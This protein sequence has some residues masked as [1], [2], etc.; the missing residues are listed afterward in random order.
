MGL[1]RY[2]LTNQGVD[3]EG[4]EEKHLCFTLEEVQ[5]KTRGE[6]SICT[7]LVTNEVFEPFEKL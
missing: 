2:I 1:I 6:F 3:A 4:S 7:D 5:L